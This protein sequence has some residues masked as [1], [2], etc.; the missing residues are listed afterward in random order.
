[1]SIF[2]IR[3]SETLVPFRL[4]VL[5]RAQ[6]SI[7]ATHTHTDHFMCVAKQIKKATTT[8]EPKSFHH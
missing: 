5:G 3:S 6:R 8:S 4:I 7:K 2:G 1:V